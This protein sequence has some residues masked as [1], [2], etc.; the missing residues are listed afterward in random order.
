MKK[1]SA[2][3]SHLPTTVSGDSRPALFC[4]VCNDIRIKSGKF[5]VTL[6]WLS[7]FVSL[8][9]SLSL[10]LSAFHVCLLQAVWPSGALK[11]IVPKVM[12]GDSL[13]PSYQP[14]NSFFLYIFYSQYIT[15]HPSTCPPK[16]KSQIILEF[17]MQQSCYEQV[18]L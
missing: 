17:S 15:G 11:I 4:M 2:F 6:A 5:R 10:S 9:L 14:P 18:K 3:I 8:V 7:P 16:Q 13:I 1:T 12:V